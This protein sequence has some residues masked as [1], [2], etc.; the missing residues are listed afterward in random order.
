MDWL[1]AGGFFI[2]L[3]LPAGIWL[4]LR[5]AR[6]WGMHVRGERLIFPTSVALQVAGVFVAYIM[7]CAL[8]LSV[9]QEPKLEFGP[10]AIMLVFVF[11]GFS[12][13]ARSIEVD[14][15]GLAKRFLWIRHKILWSEANDFLR[16]RNGS[17]VIQAES[18]R[19]LLDR[20]YADFEI[21]VLEIC[22]Q[23][24]DRQKLVEP[25]SEGPNGAVSEDSEQQFRMKTQQY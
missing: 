21:L 9:R 18:K 12:V 6:W 10:L 7:L 20:R 15:E 25:P 22:K 8:A 17:Y 24:N 1:G 16:L 23:I 11:A 19:L 4:W 3:L 5:P 14:R 2:L 13:L